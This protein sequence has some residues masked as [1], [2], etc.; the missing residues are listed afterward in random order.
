MS[1]GVRLWLELWLHF[2]YCLCSLGQVTLHLC[3]GDDN[4]VW[5]LQELKNY[6]QLMLH[7]DL[8]VKVVVALL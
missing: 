5:C 6:V 1:F 4:L 8:L 2:F 7:S 3:I